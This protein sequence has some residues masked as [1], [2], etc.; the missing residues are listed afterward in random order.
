MKL[1]L[2]VPKL[3]K[4]QYWKDLSFWQVALHDDD[5]KFIKNLKIDEELL[6][7]IKDFEIRFIYNNQ[8]WPKLNHTT[9]SQLIELE[10]FTKEE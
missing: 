5:W 10:S 3:V 4:T 7:N 2:K 9:E 1:I 6:K 8:P